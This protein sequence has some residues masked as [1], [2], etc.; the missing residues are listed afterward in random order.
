MSRGHIRPDEVGTDAEDVR[1]AW[2][3]VSES[4]TDEQLQIGK[5][6][7]YDLGRDRWT[8]KLIANRVRPYVPDTTRAIV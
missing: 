1:F 4:A 2:H 5:A 6:V 3:D 7:D 8:G